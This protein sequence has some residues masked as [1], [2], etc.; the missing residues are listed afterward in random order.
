LPIDVVARYVPETGSGTAVQQD[1]L[2]GAYFAKGH[3]VAESFRKMIYMVKNP[4]AIGFVPFLPRYIDLLK[5]EGCK[6][7]GIKTPD[8]TVVQPDHTHVKNSP[9]PM[10]VPVFLYWDKKKDRCSS[11]FSAFCSEARL[12]RP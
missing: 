10:T 12:S 2:Q 1:L 8:G 3:K 6:V 11:A 5:K 9:Y 7:I 4:Q